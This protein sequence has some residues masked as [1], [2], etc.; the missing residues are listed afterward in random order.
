MN[1][2]K[3]CWMCG[4]IIK[5]ESEQCKFCQAVQ[6]QQVEGPVVKHFHQVEP[7]RRSG[8]GFMTG[9]GCLIP[10]GFAA[11][12]FTAVLQTAT[13]KKVMLIIGG[14]IIGLGIIIWAIGRAIHWDKY[15]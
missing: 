10:I 3:H 1:N 12:I 11:M 7:I 4:H 2:T 15:A 14:S 5:F 8:K 6:N 9:G 13:E